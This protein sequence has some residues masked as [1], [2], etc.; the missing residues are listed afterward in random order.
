MSDLQPA[1]PFVVVRDL[2]PGLDRLKG[3]VVAL[4]NFDGVH[5]GHRQVIATAL[6]RAGTLGC[7][8]AALTFEPHPRAFF[9]PGEPLF[10]L[11]DERNKLRLFATTG[12]AGAVVMTFDAGLARLTA[13]EFVND[14][15][16]DRLAVS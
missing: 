1:K 9:R 7:A 15:L 11:T 4:G 6:Q 14:I 8:A 3:A 12:L 10:R 2:G 13:D 16:V 5:R